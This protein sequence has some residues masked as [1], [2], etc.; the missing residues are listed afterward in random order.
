MQSFKNVRFLLFVSFLV[1]ITSTFAGAETLKWWTGTWNEKPA[2]ELISEFEEQNPEVKIEPAF[3]PWEGMNEK[4]LVALRGGTAPD[5][6]CIAVGWVYEWAKPGLLIPLDQYIEES[7]TDFADWMAGAWNTAVVDSSVYSIPYRSD[8]YCLFYNKDLFEKIGLN[9]EQPPQNWNEYLEHAIA[10]TSESEKV[11][12]SGII[13]AGE[14]LNLNARV[15]PFVYQNSGS[16]V[17]E[18]RTKAAINEKPAVDAIKWVTD[19]YTKHHVEPPSNI[20]NNADEVFEL[21]KNGAVAMCMGAPYNIPLA[22]EAGVNLGTALLPANPDTGRRDVEMGGWNLAIT[23]YS[24][25]PGTAF[26]FI[27]F[28]V[29]PDNMARLTNALPAR[30]AA[31][32]SKYINAD[33]INDPLYKAPIEQL[34]YGFLLMVPYQQQ[35]KVIIA[36][37]IQHILIGNKDPQQAMDDAARRIDEVLNR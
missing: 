23:K 11:Y 33:F 29:Q 16:V 1:L 18:N 10:L 37:E 2:K 26:K 27:D 34:N 4:Y 21:F 15:L 12:G 31:F 32:G 9:P 35:I 19:L 17:N 3:I 6:M 36:E 24:S 8:C 5:I 20:Q 30:N 22:K 25:I 14:P 7:N 13:S 28:L